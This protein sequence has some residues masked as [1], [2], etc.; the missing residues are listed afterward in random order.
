MLLGIIKGIELTFENLACV[1]TVVS[2]R[3]K[4]LLGFSILYE[5]CNTLVCATSKG[6]N[7]PAHTRRLIN[8]YTHARTHLYRELCRQTITKTDRH[9]HLCREPYSQTD[10]HTHTHT[11]KHLYRE[12]CRQTA[13]Q[14]D[15]HT[16]T[17][18]PLQRTVQTDTHRHRHTHTH[19][20]TDRQ[21]H[22]R[23]SEGRA[24]V[25]SI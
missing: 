7:T 17:H 14:T 1:H 25:L 13:R 18:T 4:Q 2:L 24:V 10:T 6:S 23:T 15:T 21:T 12:S 22:T 20:Q 16:C 9:T 8:T 19:T 11:C 5:I 3:P